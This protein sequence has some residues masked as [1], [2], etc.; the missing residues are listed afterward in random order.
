MSR[1][2]CEII[3]LPKFL[4]GAN[5]IGL[6]FGIDSI[7]F[8][9][10]D[11]VQTMSLNAFISAEQLIVLPAGVPKQGLLKK[12]SAKLAFYQKELSKSCSSC[13]LL[14]ATDDICLPK[15]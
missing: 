4:S 7:I 13:K 15:L 12:H 8:I 2:V 1:P 5:I 10:L 14:E 6:S 3:Y 9:A 11:E